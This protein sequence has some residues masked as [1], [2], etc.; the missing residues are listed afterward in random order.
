[1]SSLSTTKTLALSGAVIIMAHIIRTDEEKNDRENGGS[2]ED[3]RAFI[4]EI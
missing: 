3:R 1:M 2:L 4:A